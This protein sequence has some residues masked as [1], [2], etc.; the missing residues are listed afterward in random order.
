MHHPKLLLIF[1]QLSTNLLH[2]L[3]VKKVLMYIDEIDERFLK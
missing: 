3:T 1:Q 2:G